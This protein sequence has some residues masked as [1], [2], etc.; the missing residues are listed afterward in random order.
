M[1]SSNNS[2]PLAEARL[3]A[4]FMECIGYGI[5]LVTLGHALHVLFSRNDGIKRPKS[6]P[7]LAS[8]LFFAV[9]TTLDVAASFRFNL[10]AFVLYRGPGGPEEVFAMVSYWT[11]VTQYACTQTTELITEVMLIYR[12]LVVYYYN[13]GII[14]FPIVLWFGNAA[15]SIAIV[16]IAAALKSDALVYA[17]QIKPFITA[18]GI[19]SLVQ[20]F[21][22]TGLIAWRI[23][24][25]TQGVSVVSTMP[26]V[27]PHTL[28]RASRIIIE[29]GAMNGVSVA[30]SFITV[31]AGSNSSY[32]SADVGKMIHG[33]TFNLII[34]RVSKGLTAGRA[35]WKGS[36]PILSSPR[37]PL[38]FVPH[39]HA[40]NGP[41]ISNVDSFGEVSSCANDS[42]TF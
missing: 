10:V 32:C 41:C 15:C 4:L 27:R 9:L 7:L 40:N 28:S 35:E 20:N 23:S 29:S 26:S 12:C 8:T 14:A 33:I 37:T 34:I 39:P 2:F 18:F 19:M 21:L 13:W 3:V 11:N 16:Y 31:I 24:R 22:C 25:I 38:E 36:L 5:Y 30:I 6:I 1:H 42:L 17:H